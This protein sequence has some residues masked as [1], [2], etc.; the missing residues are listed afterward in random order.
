MDEF[1]KELKVKEMRIFL[2]TRKNPHPSKLTMVT[3]PSS[4]DCLCECQSNTYKQHSYMKT[5]QIHI[6]KID[7]SCSLLILQDIARCKLVMFFK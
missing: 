6:E 3:L 5:T 7:L 2:K 1:L 4:A